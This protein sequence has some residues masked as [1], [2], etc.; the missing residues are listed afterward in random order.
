MSEQDAPLDF[1]AESEFAGPGAAPAG[2]PEAPTPAPPPPPAPEA[3]SPGAPA[4]PPAHA[5]P[6]VTA[7]TRPDVAA[8][9][10]E[11]RINNA[12]LVEL[13]GGV[14]GFL[15]VGHMYVGRTNDGL[16]RLIGWWLIVGA[17]WTTIALLSAIAI[18]LC[19]IPGA[20]AI[21]MGVP[22]YSAIRLR[23]TL[24]AEAGLPQR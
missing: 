21:Q 7:A 1:D 14:V 24:L 3:A 6:S 4:S 19:M 18:G 13:I 5:A 2:L 11:Q 16:V 10:Q 22:V 20:I 17:T 8:M 9:L 15:G 12:F 23:Q